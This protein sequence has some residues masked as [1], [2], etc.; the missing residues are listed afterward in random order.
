MPKISKTHWFSLFFQWF[1][2]PPQRPETWTASK[3]KAG[4]PDWI[5]HECSYQFDAYLI[6]FLPS[7]E[8]SRGFDDCLVHECPYQFDACIMRFLPSF[9]PL[10]ASMTCVS[11]PMTLVNSLLYI[12]LTKNSLC[13]KLLTSF[14]SRLLFWSVKG[15]L[16]SLRSLRCFGDFP[17][18]VVNCCSSKL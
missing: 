3:R 12:F 2:S 7:F 16:R 10:E 1:S 5:V 6:W 15:A 13:I 4:A 18:Q 11:M 17:V 8:P 9:N 14:W